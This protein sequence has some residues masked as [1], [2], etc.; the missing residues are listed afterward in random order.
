MQN[1]T[2][3]KRKRQRRMELVR[4][5]VA[6]DRQVARQ[7]HDLLKKYGIPSVVRR[8]KNTHAFDFDIELAVRQENA[9]TSY[10]LIQTTLGQDS[11]SDSFFEE[12]ESRTRVR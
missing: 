6:P 4:I 5:A 12:K 1:K 9:E 2:E 3:K 8:A 10:R 11:C 7:Y